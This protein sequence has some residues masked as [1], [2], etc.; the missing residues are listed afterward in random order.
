MDMR[1]ERHKRQIEPPSRVERL[2][3]AVWPWEQCGEGVE[4]V[5]RWRW[6]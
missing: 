5:E 6:W 3:E 1:F 2:R 4:T